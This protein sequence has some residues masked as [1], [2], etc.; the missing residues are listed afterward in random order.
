MS[1]RRGLRLPQVEAKTGLRKTQILDAVE[2]GFFPKPYKIIAGGR[3]IAWDE[4]EVDQY[5]ERRMAERDTA[6]RLTS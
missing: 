4:G 1:N 3:A 5:L 2:R 6:H